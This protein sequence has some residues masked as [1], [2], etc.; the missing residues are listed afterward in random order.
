MSH[1]QYAPLR[2]GCYASALSSQ[3]I[4][5][6]GETSVINLMYCWVSTEIDLLM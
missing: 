5:N 2:K 1:Y 3:S 4:R 6:L